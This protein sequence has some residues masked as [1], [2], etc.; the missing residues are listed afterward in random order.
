MTE[1]IE[2]LEAADTERAPAPGRDI[3]WAL[4]KVASGGSVRSR[5]WD[6]E[7]RITELRGIVMFNPFGGMYEAWLMT[8]DDIHATDWVEA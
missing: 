1:S 3:T 6:D 2:E 5:A 8:I 4:A 7:A